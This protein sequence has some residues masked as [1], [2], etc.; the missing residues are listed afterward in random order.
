MAAGLN[1][2][3]KYLKAAD[4]GDFQAKPFYE[5]ATDSLILYVRNEQSYG[6]RLNA[7]LTLF[8]STK[9]RSVVGCEVKGVS[10]ILKAAEELEVLVHDR[11]IKLLILLKMA[12]IPEP[13]DPVLA[14]R[15]D[16]E[17]EQAVRD[18]ELDVAEL[19]PA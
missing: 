15:Y 1:D 14:R 10:R 17:L 2:L 8:L 4:V 18:I 9:D 11:K 16:D 19:S 3:A 13:E 7:R 12:R 6:K 5:P